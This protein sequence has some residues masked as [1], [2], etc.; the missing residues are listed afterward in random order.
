MPNLFP[1]KNQLRFALLL[2]SAWLITASLVANTVIVNSQ[3]SFDTAHD[4]AS[5]N[6]TIVWAD[7]S[8]ANI[9]MDI[10][11][12]SLT[13]M[14]ET[15]GNTVFTG[16]SR[17]DIDGDNVNFIGFQYVGGDIGTS[18]VVNI[19]GSN[20]LFTQV[21]IRAYRCYKYLR[22]REESQYVDITYCNFENRLTVADQNILSILVDNNQPGYHKVRYCS[23][24]NFPGGGNDEGVEP[25]RIGVSTQA[26]FNSRS[27]VEYCYFTQC[28]GDGELISSKASQ[29]VYRFNTFEDNTKAELVLRHGSEAI[30][31]GN[32]FLRGKGGIRVREGQDHYIYNNYFFDIDD[33]P[34]YL[35]NES[36]DPLDNINVAFNTIIDCKPVILG[37]EN[38]DDPPTDVTFANNIFDNPKNSLFEDAT[39]E[40]TWIGNITSGSLGISRPSTGLVDVNPQ[41]EENG[42][43][44]F[45]LAA[46]SPAIDAAL[47]GFAALPQFFGMEPI[48]TDI[49]F[50]LMNQPRPAAVVEKDLGASEFPH[51]VAI[52]PIAT[53]E[54]TGPDYNTS[55]LPSVL[56]VEW[57]YFRGEA[58]GKSSLLTWATATETLTDRFG[59]E[60]LGPTGEWSEIGSVEATGNGT[61]YQFLDADPGPT[62]PVLYRLRQI[63]LDG[64]FVYSNIASVNFPLTAGSTTVSPNPTFGPLTIITNLNADRDVPYRIINAL[65]QT[66][67]RGLF[68]AGR[69]STELMLAQ[70]LKAGTYFLSIGEES[71][72]II[73]R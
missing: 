3:Q 71:L 4:N 42:D 63:D 58:R 59:V 24:K 50:D 70:K 43:G 51:T 69:G 12:N 49:L 61:E 41:L 33:R 6:D 27:L 22:V 44:F 68:P 72:P 31:Y 52:S 29:N 8:Y 65:G 35:Q 45:G 7:G 26:D 36:S 1:L 40:E 25:I 32:F 11:K 17:A 39:G 5:A 62:S 2:F 67:M 10:E 64:S 57:H 30:V 28:D 60:R 9:F 18:N 47:P 66:V 16:S 19:R 54:N 23:F 21:N 48:D 46:G 13:V 14:S 55:I 15:L 34:I 37:G 20:I 53:E 38:N 56:P 73:L